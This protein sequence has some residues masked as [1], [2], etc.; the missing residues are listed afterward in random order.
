MEAKRNNQVSLNSHPAL[1]DE[2]LRPPARGE[3]AHRNSRQC[4]FK[5]Q[6]SIYNISIVSNVSDKQIA[7]TQRKRETI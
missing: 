3:A 1:R 2:M 4:L 7:G 6:D 5:Y